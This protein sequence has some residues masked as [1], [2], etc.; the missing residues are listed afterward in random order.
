MSL[1]DG[2]IYPRDTE[3]EPFA[4]FDVASL[5]EILQDGGYYNMISG[6]WH[7]GFKQ[8]CNPHARGFHRSLA[9][10]PGTTNHFAF[11]PQLGKD[12]WNEFFG[13]IPVLY[14]EEGKRKVL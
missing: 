12:D 13:R 11:E 6:K 3:A 10:L 1:A 9:M 14:T 5:P 8:E 7:L 2:F 4:D